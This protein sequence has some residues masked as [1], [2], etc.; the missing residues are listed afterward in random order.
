MQQ[1][2]RATGLA[3]LAAMGAAT[4]G[5]VSRLGANI[6][7]SNLLVLALALVS[8]AASSSVAMSFLGGGLLSRQHLQWQHL[9]AV[10]VLVLVASSSVAASWTAV[11]CLGGR[12]RWQHII[13]VGICGGIL[14]GSVRFWRQACVLHLGGLG[15]DRIP[16]CLRPWAAV[17]CL[18]GNVFGGDTPFVLAL[19]A[20]SSTTA[21]CFYGDLGARRSQRSQRPDLLSRCLHMCSSVVSRWQCIRWQCIICAGHGGGIFH[22]SF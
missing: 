13:C 2:W 5:A 9:I 11:S 21:S 10:T 7:G 3:R 12:L 20:V 4:L 15:G 17:S 14:R 1:S 18:G 19:E 6:F 22:S 16:R 8:V